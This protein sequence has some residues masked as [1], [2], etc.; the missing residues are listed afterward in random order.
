MAN[1]DVK[2]LRF[3]V[4][5]FVQGERDAKTWLRTLLSAATARPRREFRVLL[6]NV[7]FNLSEG[8][9]MAIIGRNGAGKSTLLRLLTGAFCPTG[10]SLEVNG[11]RQ[12]LLNISLGFNPE[13]TLVE[14][15]YLRS[16]AMG[17]RSRK[18][19][20]HIPQI[21]EFAGLID[22]AHHRLKTLS[23]GQRMRLGFAISTSEQQDIMLLD[24]WLGTGDAE[25]LE[26]ARERMMDRVEGSKIVVLASHNLAL[27]Q[28]VCNVGLVLEQGHV[29]YFGPITDALDAYSSLIKQP[30][31]VMA[32]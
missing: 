30:A 23:A 21:L 28:Q 26:K 1:I 10:G 15:I 31:R 6:D 27:L 4:P 29:E 18:I 32:A 5:L 2:N 3:E 20:E 24:E 22:R 14:N 13:A 19:A 8:Q 12:A 11:S 7:T 9:R 16:T 17:M 25:F